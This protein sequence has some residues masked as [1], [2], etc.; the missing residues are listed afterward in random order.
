MDDR[1]KVGDQ[2]DS[3]VRDRVHKHDYL[4]QNEDP[5][6]CSEVPYSYGYNNSKRC[7]LCLLHVAK[8]ITK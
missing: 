1:L 8:D 3:N 7:V 4:L 2:T 5:Q 6:F